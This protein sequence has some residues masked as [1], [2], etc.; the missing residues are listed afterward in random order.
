MPELPDPR[1]EAACKAIA[2][3]HP[4]TKAY[5]MAGYKGSSR[6]VSSVFFRRPKIAA[7]IAELLEARR[8]VDNKAMLTAAERLSIDKYWVLE[9]LKYNAEVA[10]RGMPVLDANGVQ[11][12]R[13]S[14]RPNHNAATRA[15]ALIGKELGMF[16]ERIEIGGPGE[17]ASMSDHELTEKARQDALALGMPP[18]AIEKLLLTF[19]PKDEEAVE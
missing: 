13:F 8:V 17:F 15:L 12:G 19:Q 6:S 14:G 5:A 10:L 7:R 11:T 1:W 4:A 9:R 18:E 16:V 2:D 3:G